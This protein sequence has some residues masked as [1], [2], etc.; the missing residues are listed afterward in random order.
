MS[1]ALVAA[2]SGDTSLEQRDRD[3]RFTRALE[4]LLVHSGSTHSAVDL[5]LL[6]D[7][8]AGLLQGNAIDKLYRLVFLVRP[9]NLWRVPSPHRLRSPHGGPQ[10]EFGCNH[11]PTSP[12]SPS[13]SSV[14]RHR[15]SYTS[16]SST[17]AMGFSICVMCIRALP[18]ARAC[19]LVSSCGRCS[20]RTV[21][22]S[23]LFITIQ[24]VTPNPQTRISG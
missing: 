18:Q 7:G 17:V 12:P 24:V 1:L 5:V 16:R 10:R 8:P 9:S 15:S 20:K 4:V 11:Q 19:A 23:P 13:R 2:V 21:L 6:A 14:G 3:E 22:G